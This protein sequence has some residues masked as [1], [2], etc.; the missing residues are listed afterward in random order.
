MWK[1]RRRLWHTDGVLAESFADAIL[2]KAEWLVRNWRVKRIAEDKWL[3]IGVRSK[4]IIKRG[5]TGFLY[6]NCK[7]FQACGT[8]SHTVAVFLYE[9]GR[10]KAEVE[11]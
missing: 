4:H 3:V 1:R 10:V 5:A 9:N 8:C 2:K 6:C 7:G 11:A